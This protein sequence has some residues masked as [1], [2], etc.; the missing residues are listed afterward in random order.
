MRLRFHVALFTA[1]FI[2]A[3]QGGGSVS[4]LVSAVRADLQ[5]NH[6]DSQMA[7]N[8]RKVKLSE[9][10]DDRTIEILQSEGAGPETVG[11]LL[12]LRD[13]SERMRPPAKP[14]IEPPPPPAAAEQAQIWNAAHENSL[15]YT[16]S[17]PNFICSEV[18]RRYTDPNEKG[19]WRLHDTLVL[20][21]TYFD[22]QEE[23]KLMTVNNHSTNMS[24]EDVGGAITE[25]E[26]GSMLAAIFALKSRTNRDWDHWSVLRSRPTHVYS[27]SITAA[28]SDYGITAGI[29]ARGGGR[30][31]AG[32]HGY[33]Y[34]DASTRMV[35]RVTAIADSLPPDFPVRRVDLTL[36]YD[37]IDVGGRHF[38]LPL[39]S[40]TLLDAPPFPLRNETD[41]LAYRKFSADTT[42][43]YDGVGKK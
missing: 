22:K 5:R 2:G 16:D 3:A 42:V 25:G 1:C 21:L 33:V 14:A 24:Y 20:K 43:T 28:N 13:R 30:V 17:L 34:I 10:L 8:L 31:T 29:G 41:F 12:L 26:F 18:V 37:F 38:L 19:A 32:Q 7:K 23:Y 35:V 6:S 36:D 40:E 27:F 11:Q 39:H 9:R 15:N 4:D